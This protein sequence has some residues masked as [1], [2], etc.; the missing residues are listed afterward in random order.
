MLVN[1]GSRAE[2]VPGRHSPLSL[3]LSPSPA[4][5]TCAAYGGQIMDKSTK[6]EL[7]IVAVTCLARLIRQIVSERLA[8]VV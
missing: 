4:I 6:C 7:W 3:E 2:K 5:L 1:N 8:S